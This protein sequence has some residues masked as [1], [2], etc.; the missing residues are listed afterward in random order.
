[1]FVFLS[2]S[3]IREKTISGDFDSWQIILRDLDP[4]QTP[5]QREYALWSSAIQGSVTVLAGIVYISL[6]ASHLV[7]PLNLTP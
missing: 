7:P 2:N 3:A 1:M 6:D 5:D 4:S